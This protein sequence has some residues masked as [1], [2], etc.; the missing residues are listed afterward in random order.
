MNMPATY[1]A[2]HGDAM[3]REGSESELLE[4]NWNATRGRAVRDMMS[5]D[6]CGRFCPKL[7]H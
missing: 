4:L 6:C 3:A 2:R 7:K 1:S 5:V